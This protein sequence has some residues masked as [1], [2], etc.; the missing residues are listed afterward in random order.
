[1]AKEGLFNVLV[2]LVDFQELQVLDLFAGT[3]S[4]SFEFASRGAGSVTSVDINFRCVDFIK[5]TAREI[6]MDSLKVVRADVFR[7]LTKSKPGS[8]DLIFADAPFDLKEVT[9]LPDLILDTGWLK[10]N[11]RLIIE[12]PANVDFTR[13]KYFIE[14]RNYGKVH[15]SFFEQ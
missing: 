5:K 9:Q 14:K 11:A 15:F 10:K 4:I 13:H 8:Y 7:F 12:H 6:G 2:H 3:G 1:M